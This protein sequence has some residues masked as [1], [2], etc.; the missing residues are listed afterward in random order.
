MIEEEP[1]SVPDSALDDAPYA[2]M[3]I[4]EGLAKARYAFQA[5]NDKELSFRKVL[6]FNSN[7]KTF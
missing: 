3:Q 1:E 2:G 4:E 5:E 6:P 7:F